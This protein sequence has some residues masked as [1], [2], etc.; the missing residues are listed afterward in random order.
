MDW[1]GEIMTDD[2]VD[3]FPLL[4]LDSCIGVQSSTIQLNITA[5]TEEARAKNLARV[6]A[7][8]D[9]TK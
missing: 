8:Q 1:E 9:I 4:V 5:R 2:A 7:R 3:F 6:Q